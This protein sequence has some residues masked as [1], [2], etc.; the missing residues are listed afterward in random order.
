[1]TLPNVF[2]ST[3]AGAQRPGADLDTNFN[4]VGFLGMIPCTV[5]GV[6]T[7][8][9]TPIPGTAPNVTAYQNY[10]NFIFVAGSNSSG[11]VTVQ[12]AGGAPAVNLYKAGGAVQAGS[13]D[14][15]ASQLYIITYNSALNTGAGGF[16]ITSLT[17]VLTQGFGTQASIASASTTDLGTLT[18]NNALITGTVTITALGS[19]ASVTAPVWLVKFNGAL[20]LTYNA[21]SLILP[22]AANITT[23]ANDAALFLYLGS[24]NWQCLAYFRG[25][26]ATVTKGPTL[27]VFTSGSGTYTTP[28][29][30]KWIRVRMVGGGAGGA[31]SGTGS[32]GTG[33]VG[34]SSTFGSSFLTCT[35]GAIQAGAGGVGSGGDFNIAGGNG[36]GSMPDPGASMYGSAG[37][38]S[39]YGAQGYG[40]AGSGGSAASGAGS[41]GAG[42]GG[43]HA[44]GVG[45][46][47]GGSAGGYLEKT[48]V[49]PSATYA[50]SVGAAGTGGAAGTNGFVGGAGAAGLI[51]VEEYYT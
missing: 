33:T 3:A 7:L 4:A 36:Q 9:L 50:Y 42:G 22:G 2:A 16:V 48:I 28:T 8:V 17:G 13:G 24:G 27:Q 45:P 21:S 35:G 38:V 39:F 14:L 43:N 41:G 32:P 15:V 40:I 51:I 37:G 47:A 49:S 10:M 31:G 30:V 20:T 1:M 5:A 46:A 11:S 18:G 29:G 6:N 26:G 12:V 23:V 25:T 19:S 34:Q 44:S